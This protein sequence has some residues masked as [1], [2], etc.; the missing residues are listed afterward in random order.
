MS[1]PKQ[2]QT[3]RRLVTSLS[4]SSILSR[5]DRHIPEDPNLQQRC[6]DLKSRIQ[7]SYKYL[8]CTMHKAGRRYIQGSLLGYFSW[9]WKNLFLDFLRFS[10]ANCHS[11]IAVQLLAAVDSSTNAARTFNHASSL[12]QFFKIQCT[13]F[14]LYVSAIKAIFSCNCSFTLHETNCSKPVSSTCMSP[15]LSHS[16][17]LLLLCYTQSQLT[18]W[19][20]CEN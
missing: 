6:E 17:R 5:T 3:F 12:K 11:T 13:N 20:L 8:G 9:Y 15:S 16:V 10:A 1:L 4:V 2:F 19:T 7:Y 14:V 18:D